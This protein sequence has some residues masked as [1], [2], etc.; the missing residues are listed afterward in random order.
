ME[1]IICAMKEKPDPE[2]PIEEFL[3]G[4]EAEVTRYPM[5]KKAEIDLGNQTA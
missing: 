1:Q 2:V 4:L 3:R 5:L